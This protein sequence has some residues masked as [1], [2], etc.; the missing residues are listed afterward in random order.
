MVM[1]YLAHLLMLVS[2]VLCFPFRPLLS[3]FAA[4]TSAAARQGQIYHKMRKELKQIH[5]IYFYTLP[6]LNCRR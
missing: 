1:H 3:R 4:C 2:A 6:R 5:K